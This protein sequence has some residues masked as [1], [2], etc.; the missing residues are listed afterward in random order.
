[1][2]KELEILKWTDFF[3]KNIRG[4]I[5]QKA[6]SHYVHDLIINNSVVILDFN[7]LSQLLGIRPKVLSGIIIKSDSFY[8]NF[9]LPKRSGGM[10]EISS[11][12][13]ILLNAQKWIYNNILITQP[14]HKCSKGFMKNVSIVD[15]AK[16]HLNKRFL[17]KMD[18][19]N[20][21]PSIKINRIISVFLYL[22]YTKK[23]SYYLASIC[24]INGALPQGAPTSPMLSNIISKRLD[25]RLH[26]L[27]I[28][29]NLNYTRYADDLTFSGNVLPIKIINY[30][31]EI[32]RDEGFEINSKKTKLL[33]TKK[34]KI[35]TGISISSGKLT[36][37][38]KAKREI[39]KNVYHL[40]TKGIF[41]HQKSIGSTDPIYL[42]RILGYLYFW[43][44]IEPNNTF[45]LNSIGLLRKYS[46]DLDEKFFSK[47]DVR[48]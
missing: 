46:N 7:H 27:A 10:R 45:I 33:S 15:N 21:F 25:R 26:G 13:P 16:E 39:R 30:I 38:K 24:C 12:F 1:M 8:Y 42:E 5:T 22:G 36:I 18:I 40:L 17:L 43:L 6:L 31:E 9:L 41:E 32:V 4:K 44:S 37:P 14:L 29:F 35:V 47:T 19:E 48:Q 23:I 34:Q 28:R 3:S 20:F 11:P 2:E